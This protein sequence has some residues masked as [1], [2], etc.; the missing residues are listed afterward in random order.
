MG[1]HSH[2][3][4]IASQGGRCSLLM[5]MQMS[6]SSTDVCSCCRR[7]EACMVHLVTRTDLPM[8]S[9][10]FQCMAF[11]SRI[12]QK[13]RMPML[14]TCLLSAPSALN[15]AISCWILQWGNPT[16]CLKLLALCFNSQHSS[17]LRTAEVCRAV[18]LTAHTCLHRRLPALL[19][20]PF[21]GGP[22]PRRFSLSSLARFLSIRSSTYKWSVLA[23]DSI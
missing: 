2:S 8:A 5:R 21:F 23:K 22:L 14:C 12:Y 9:S 17:G 19:P 18:R 7:H 15:D 3:C 13:S 1:A 11:V 4:L 16:V 20:C 10:R 6:A